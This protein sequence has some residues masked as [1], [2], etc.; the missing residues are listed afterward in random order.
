MS[1]KDV[2]L[3][4]T[5]DLG[6]MMHYP[7]EGVCSWNWFYPYHYAPF[8]YD[9]KDLGEINSIFNLGTPFKPIDQLLFPAASSHALP[10][11]CDMETLA[12]L[13]FSC[14]SEPYRNLITDSSSPIIDFYPI[15]FEGDMNGKRYAWQD[16]SSFTN[17][18]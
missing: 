14:T 15:D 3:K 17:M 4:Y 13:Q 2:V 1:R 12:S 11:P 16:Y 18:F 10:E 5:E 9:L 7:Y 8:A 6:W